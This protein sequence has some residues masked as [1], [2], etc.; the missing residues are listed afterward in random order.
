MPQKKKKKK[1]NKETRPTM[2]FKKLSISDSFLLYLRLLKVT[3]I[4][5]LLVQLL[6]LVLW[7][8]Y[9]KYKTISNVLRTKK[10]DLVNEILKFHYKNSFY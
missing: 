9:R 2:H 6:A 8:P 4:P 3:K 10:F 5:V 1:F 7:D